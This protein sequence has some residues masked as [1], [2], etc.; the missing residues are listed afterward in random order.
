MCGSELPDEAVFCTNCCAACEDEV[1]NTAVLDE[2]L[3]EAEQS[4]ADVEETTVL[5]FN[6]QTI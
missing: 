3:V 1:E 4:S 2:E 5:S 6:N